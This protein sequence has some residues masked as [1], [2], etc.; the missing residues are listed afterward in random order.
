MG[1]SN[2]KKD[3]NENTIINTDYVSDDKFESS[4]IKILKTMDI[5]VN[6]SRIKIHNYTALPDQLDD[7]VLRFI[8]PITKKL[9]ILNLLKRE[10]LD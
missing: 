4:I 5:E 2:Q 1:V 9:K 6:T 3:Q 8:D 10:L 7:F